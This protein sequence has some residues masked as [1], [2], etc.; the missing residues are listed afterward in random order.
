MTY[1]P[2]PDE[3]VG[4]E[5]SMAKHGANARKKD[6]LRIPCDEALR[7]ESGTLLFVRSHKRLNF[8]SIAFFRKARSRKR[9]PM[10]LKY[11]QRIFWLG[12]RK[13]SVRL[14]KERALLSIRDRFVCLDL[15]RSCRRR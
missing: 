14:T 3:P 9:A 6:A 4:S 2:R 5:I 10:C 8:E 12:T 15:V 1:A 13:R 11:C 7:S